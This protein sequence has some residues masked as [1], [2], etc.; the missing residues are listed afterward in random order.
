MEIQPCL[1]FREN[2]REYLGAHIQYFVWNGAILSAVYA[3]L[4][5]VAGTGLAHCKISVQTNIKTLVSRT[6]TL[7]L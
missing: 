5:L 6:I 4:E 1:V 2:A 3:F 7:S